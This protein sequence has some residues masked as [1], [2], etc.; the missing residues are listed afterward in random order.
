MIL[1]QTYELLKA[2]HK[3]KLNNISITDVRIGIFL[4]AIQLSD[5]S[6]GAASTNLD[7]HSNPY[8]KKRQ[9]DSFSPG[10]I[11]GQKIIDLFENHYD[12]KIINT[13]KVAALNALSSGI[14]S[15]SHYKI[16]EGADPVDLLDLTT[17]KTISIVGAFQSYIK[18]IA[19]TGN[20][21][22]VLELDED[23]LNEDQKQYFVPAYRYPEILPASDAVIITGLTL[24]NNTLDDLLDAV[25]PGAQVVVTG[26]SSSLIPDVLFKNKVKILGG[27]RIT[28]PDILFDIVS[29]AGTGFHLFKYC[30]QKFCIVNE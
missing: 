14:I 2:G 23:A 18:I 22:N 5:G 29:Q 24:V 10:Q 9:F 21:L 4:T 30:A 19:A 11:K 7:A 27:T 17:P 3:D 20:K 6:V 13:L 15:S 8:I 12:I 16:L 26:P 1:D 28:I 25:A